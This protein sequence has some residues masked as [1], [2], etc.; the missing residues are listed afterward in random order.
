MLGLLVAAAIAAPVNPYLASSTY[1]LPHRSSA[2]QDATP[3]A[4]PTAPTHALRADEIDYVH[5]GPGH[6][7]ALIS[8]PYPDGR[9]VIWS[10][11]LN[12]VYKQDHDTFRVLAHLP[13][14]NREIFDEARADASV[15][16]FDQSNDGFFALVHAFREARMF[17]DLA[18]VYTMVDR[19]NRFYVGEKRGAI[20]VYGDGGTPASAIE[21][22]GEYILPA[23]ITGNLIGI[24]MTFDGWIV[25]ATEHGYVVAVS[26]DLKHS[27]FVKL[28]HSER[29]AEDSTRPGY[30]WI[31]NSFA[32]D[33]RGGIYVAS[34]E[35]LHKVVWTGSRLSTDEADGAWCEPY[36]NGDGD[37]T[38]ATPAL[39]GFGDEDHLVAM[40]DGDA[41]MNLTLFWRDAIPADWQ[42]IPGAPSRRTAA[43][44]P[45]DMGQP[46]LKAVQSEQAVLVSGYGALVVNNTPRNEPWYLLR[47]ARSLLISFLGSSPRYQPFGV[48]KFVWDPAAHRLRSAW[49][50]T[51]VSSPNGVPMLSLG[52]N[53]IYLVGARDNRWTLEALNWDSG[54]SDFH[55]TVGDQR[56]NNLFSGVI[57]DEAGRP[58][59]GTTWGRVRLRPH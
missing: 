41:R 51:E 21:P 12:S 58:I 16:A 20:A 26:R 42:G 10:N 33:E 46:A 56:Y 22:K 39:M 2:Q 30:G 59:Y 17:R 45:A 24:N 5:L 15:A 55:Y 48:E 47:Q 28:K 36:A 43:R 3:I 13:N 44:A 25:V 31:R 37:G 35:H 53:E 1:P 19:D 18:G 34:R 23:P 54:R 38:G 49:T 11:G 7:G 27:R 14:G 40:T 6:F 9:R 4:G 8:P 29:A 52:S 32:V 57:L 50:N